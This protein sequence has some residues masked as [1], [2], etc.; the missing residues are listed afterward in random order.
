MQNFGTNQYVHP[1]KLIVRGQWDR[2]AM[3]RK[4]TKLAFYY[5]EYNGCLKDVKN[6][7]DIV[8]NSVGKVKLVNAELEDSTTYATLCFMF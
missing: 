6:Y 7:A 8:D 2:C 1:M 5:E 3:Q 4:F